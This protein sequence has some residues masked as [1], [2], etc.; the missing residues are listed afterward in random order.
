MSVSERYSKNF[1]T[2]TKEEFERVRKS[3]VCIVGCGGLGGFVGNGLARFGVGNLTLVDGDC[4]AESNLNRQLFSTEGSL[5]AGKAQ[6]V[7]EGL[8]KINSEIEVQV[9]PTMLTEENADDIIAGQS[10]VIDCLDNVEARLLLAARCAE[11]GIPVVHGAIS[12]LF[13]QVACVYPGDGLMEILYPQGCDLQA[14]K[15]LGNPVFTPQLISA[16]ECSEA[17]KLLSGRET[18]RNKVLYIDLGS[19]DF[20]IVDFSDIDT[21]NKS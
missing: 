17:I 2:F 1:E 8:R 6:T 12:G 21:N 14:S 19:L 13:G 7:A 9:R 3:R 20:E 16:I 11:K 10:L 18:L 4:Y 15:K 5:G